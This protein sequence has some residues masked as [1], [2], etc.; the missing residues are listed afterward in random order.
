[1]CLFGLEF[2][3]DARPGVGLMDHMVV[4]SFVF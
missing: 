4:L 2:G 3:L 1:M